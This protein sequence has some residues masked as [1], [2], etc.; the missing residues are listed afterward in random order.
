MR[1]LAALIQAGDTTQIETLLNGAIET[2]T[3]ASLVYDKIKDPSLLEFLSQVPPVKEPAVPALAPAPA[4]AP[5]PAPVPDAAMESRLDVL[6]DSLKQAEARADA[7]QLER[8]V[9][10]AQLAEAVTAN[11]RTVGLSSALDEARKQTERVTVEL[12]NAR[13]EIAALKKEEQHV[14]ATV[15]F[16]LPVVFNNGLPEQIDGDR[17]AADDLPSVARPPA[18]RQLRA[19]SL[20]PTAPKTGRASNDKK[21]Q[22]TSARTNSAGSTSFQTDRNA[23]VQ[24]K[25]KRLQEREKGV[26]PQGA[27]RTARTRPIELPDVLR[28]YGLP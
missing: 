22:P 8:D 28:P 23:S 16:Q 18:T 27:P 2:G 6:Q 1:R 19:P 10:R 13:S 20:P 12:A 4:P 17:G 21:D 5:T 3:A 25:Q 24:R 14:P 11:E 9:A 15:M 7:A 26:E